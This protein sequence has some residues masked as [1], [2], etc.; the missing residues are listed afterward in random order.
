MESVKNL[1]DELEALGLNMKAEVKEKSDK[2]KG[3]TFVVTGTLEAYTRNEAKDLI[4]SLGGKVSSSVSKKTSFVLAG[5]DPGS[6]LTKA[7]ELGV[8]VLTEAEFSEMIK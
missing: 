8:R 4:E 7:N 2:F 5:E 3:L 6:K 1:I